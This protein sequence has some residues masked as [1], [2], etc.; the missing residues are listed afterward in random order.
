MMVQPLGKETD[1]VGIGVY[2]HCDRKL[3]WDGYK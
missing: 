2:L 1:G 3:G